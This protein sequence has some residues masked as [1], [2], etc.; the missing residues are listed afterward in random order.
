MLQRVAAQRAETQ[1]LGFARPLVDSSALDNLI[2]GEA[3]I[4]VDEGG[5][6]EVEVAAAFVGHGRWCWQRRF[7]WWRLSHVRRYHYWLG[8]CY[9]VRVLLVR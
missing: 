2:K 6:I 9:L 5:G 3:A 7:A 1:Y 8:P 4:L